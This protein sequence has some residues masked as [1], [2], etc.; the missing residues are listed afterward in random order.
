[1]MNKKT[2]EYLALVRQKTGFSDYKIAQKYD[3]N[4]SNL[5]KY[6]SGKAALSET[7]AW[8]F[9]NILDLDPAEVVANTK[10][11]HAINTGNNTKAIF[12][13][14][15]LNKIF[16]DIE[17]IKIQI[18]QFNAIVGDIESN[19]QK[20]LNLIH[21][22]AELGAHLI[23][24]PELA[25]TGYP[26]EDLLFRDGFI[27]QVNEQIDFLCKSVPSSISVLFGAPNKTNDSLFNSAYCIQKN[28]IIH[29]YNKQKLPNYGVFDEK[30][31][32]SPGD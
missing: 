13:Q 16:S 23:V 26:P 30:R 11:E 3:I 29:I 7:H 20:M 17:P 12:W 15:Q 31:Y 8:L 2:T 27:N 14:E 4:Q 1:M 6:S 28:Q 5:S 21:D 9:A 25:L 18:A 32:F 19:A 22:A 10:Y 24:F